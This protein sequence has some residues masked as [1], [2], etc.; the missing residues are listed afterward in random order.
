VG[1]VTAVAPAA[2]LELASCT[3]RATFQGPDHDPEPGECGQSACRPEH[4]LR[5]MRSGERRCLERRIQQCV[6]VSGRRLGVVSASDSG[7][8]GCARDFKKGGSYGLSG[9]GITGWGE[10]I[11]NFSVG[12]TDF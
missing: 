9:I 3:D 2:S 5:R 8:T 11:Y 7:A 6:P 10:R 12:G 1:M 4:E